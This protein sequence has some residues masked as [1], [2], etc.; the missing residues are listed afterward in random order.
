MKAS[1]FQHEILI[2]GAGTMGA[3]LAQNYAQNGFRVALLDISEEIVQ[4]G[5][6]TIQAELDSARGKI[7]SNDEIQAI[8]GRIFPTTSYEDACAS[9]SLRLIVEAATENIEI[10]KKIFA[11]LD[12]LAPIETV[13]A[14]N[15]SSL[16]SNILAVSTKRPDR[17]VW[18][19]YFY[20]PH[21][22]RG[23]EFA[24]TDTASQQ[25]I[26]IA[27]E[28]LL[29]GGKIPSFVR[30]SRKGGVAD[31]IFVSLLLEATRML[32]DGYRMSTVE[33]AGKRAFNIPIG[34]FELMDS[35]GLPIGL[36]SMQSFSDASDANDPLFKVY[37]N[38]FAPRQN[39]FD[40]MQRF[41]A[42]KDGEE[43]IWF[44]PDERKLQRDDE[45]TINTLVA[46]FHAI[47]FL[48]GVEV[49]D[50][51]LIT[52]EDLEILCQ[53]AF[54]WKEGPFTIMQKVGAEYVKTVVEARE[55][56]AK[57]QKQDFPISK[58]LRSYM[59]KKEPIAVHVHRIQQEN[60]FDGAVR[61]IT[62][63][64]PRAANA[65][66]N[67]V[68]DEWTAAFEQ[69]NNDPK[70]KVIVF[71]TA[72][73]KTFIAGADIPTFIQHIKKDEIGQIV[74]D[75]RR[76]QQVIF[77]L[78]TGTSKPKIAI[79]D[80]KALGGGVEVASAFAHDPNSF[81]I[82]TTRTSFTLPET[83]LG[84]YP[85]LRGTIVFP[86]VIAQ[87]TNDEI[88]ALAYSR[89][90]ILSGLTS[91][92]AHLL[93]HLGFADALVEPQ[94]RN[95]AA[96]TIAEWTLANGRIP[97]SE[98]CISMVFDR[99]PPSL[100]FREEQEL[101]VI[102]DLFTMEDVIPSLYAMARGDREPQ[103]SGWRKGFAQT[104]ARRV[105][106]ASPF[107]ISKTDWL[108][109]SAFEKYS[110]GISNDVIAEYELSQHLGEIFSHP[111]ALNGLQS[112]MR[113]A[114]PVFERRYPFRKK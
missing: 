98:E 57:K 87:A 89:Y 47:G 73:I 96:R 51:G 91:S 32:E 39:Y 49:V 53:N 74:E 19:H 54:L 28:Y 104:I 94:H 70:C 7:F 114:F 106:S 50:A 30:G 69:A 31:I 68:F 93:A 17:V 102:R 88:T 58:L 112:T 97:S 15:S 95:S 11:Q 43:I 41:H 42:R 37:G 71:D 34:F 67:I 20:L 38:F 33:E 111:D 77:K 64:H 60:E 29:L 92:S 27:R 13:I 23:G 4:R 90:M 40:I 56:L 79:V 48:T 99:I 61:W 76:W 101:G 105:F 59:S 12:A 14:T 63:S 36:A 84:I 110:N 10:K 6:K 25:S 72:P 46:R 18:M 62:L 22:N 107:A 83:R 24:G 113:G 8:M 52:I 82:M 45:Q 65:M 100:S 75:T 66:D 103:L 21:K 86:Q 78:M 9:S 55:Q 81:V 16:D 80:G 5:V 85:G 1:T 2:V 44:T 26:R 109:N 108:I 35:T 3:S